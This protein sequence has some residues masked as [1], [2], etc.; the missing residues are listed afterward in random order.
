MWVLG[1]GEVVLDA[2]FCDR[3]RRGCAAFVGGLEREDVW[4]AIEGMSGT[5]GRGGE[6]RGVCVDCGVD[7][8]VNTLGEE[9]VLYF[10]GLRWWR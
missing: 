6:R 1:T 10:E 2:D 4:W 5:V 3:S 7:G 8:L 9:D